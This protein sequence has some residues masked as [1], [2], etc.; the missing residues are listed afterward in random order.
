MIVNLNGPYLD[1]S[2]FNSLPT[3]INNGIRV[4]ESKRE[5]DE[6][7]EAESD[8]DVEVIETNKVDTSE[9]DEESECG[10]CE[11]CGNEY[12]KCNERICDT[13]EAPHY[14]CICYIIL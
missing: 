8:T 10:V 2:H 12:C 3:V 6:Q 7:N 11:S 14:D 4:A 13:C 1:A 9:D 5:A